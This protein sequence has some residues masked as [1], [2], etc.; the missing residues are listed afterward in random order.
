VCRISG[1]CGNN[2]VGM[3]ISWLSS[4]LEFLIHFQLGFENGKL[5]QGENDEHEGNF[6]KGYKNCFN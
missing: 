1:Y 5:R 4:D 6:L 2:D 3:E